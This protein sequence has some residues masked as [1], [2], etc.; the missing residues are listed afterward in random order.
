MTLSMKPPYYYDDYGYSYRKY[1]RHSEYTGEMRALRERRVGIR[2][3]A[4]F[5]GHER[6]PIKRLSYDEVI[7]GHIKRSRSAERLKQYVPERP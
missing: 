4:I 2:A 5:A 3:A 1:E 7:C 6:L